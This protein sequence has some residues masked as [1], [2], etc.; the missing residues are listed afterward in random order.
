MHNYGATIAM[1]GL[2]GRPSL[3]APLAREDAAWAADLCCTPSGAQNA[4]TFLIL[5]I[6]AI[7][8]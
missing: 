1:I 8:P 4:V 6:F 7:L 2:R 5:F 3:L